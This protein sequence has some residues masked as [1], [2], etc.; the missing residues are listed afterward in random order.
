MSLLTEAERELID[1]ARMVLAD[2]TVRL[3]ER[4]CLFPTN[5]ARSRA[6]RESFADAREALV[7]RLQADYGT[8]RHEIAIALLIDAQGRLISIKQFPEGKASRVEV[9]FRVL[10]GWIVESGA[11]AVLLAHNH[12]SGNCT[13]SRQDVELTRTI[14]AWLKPMDCE[15]IDHLVVT[16]SDCSMITGDWV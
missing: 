15:L 9:S 7:T 6:D 2:V 5:R 4:H 11:C 16:A 8:L 14:K 1:A 10:A 12:P 3:S 13:P